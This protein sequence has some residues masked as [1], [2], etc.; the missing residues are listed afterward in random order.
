MC[1]L[2]LEGARN[3]FQSPRAALHEA[4][5]KA[6]SIPQRASTQ[7]LRDHPS[8]T[9]AAERTGTFLCKEEGPALPA[10]PGLP[11]AAAPEVPTAARAA[12]GGGVRAARCPDGAGASRRAAARC[13]AS[14]RS[15]AGP[16]RPQ[17][18]GRGQA[19]QA[20]RPPASPPQ[21]PPGRHLAGPAASARRLRGAPGPSGDSGRGRRRSPGR[22][23]PGPAVPEERGRAPAA[24]PPLEPVAARCGAEVRPHGLREHEKL[25]LARAPARRLPD[26]TG[27]LCLTAFCWYFDPSIGGLIT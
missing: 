8:G 18:G 1:C 27:C 25:P 9:K 13:R 22:L 16:S 20:R 26:R 7:G 11:A 19:P 3:T 5:V 10:S 6:V 24:G 12:R 4:V 21:R 23:G 17:A 15:P 14:S 2:S